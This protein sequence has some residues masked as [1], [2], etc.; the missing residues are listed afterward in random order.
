MTK[1]S[2]QED[3]SA[4]ARDVGHSTGDYS[5]TKAPENRPHVESAVLA[6]ILRAARVERMVLRKASAWRH[7]TPRLGLARRA[8]QSKK[9]TPWLSETCRSPADAFRRSQPFGRHRCERER[10]LRRT[11]VIP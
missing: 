10:R 8:V 7:L 6:K 11:G 4:S 2:D 3:T 5:A 9:Q 1:H